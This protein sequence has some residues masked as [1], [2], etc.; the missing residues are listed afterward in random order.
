MH[1]VSRWYRAPEAIFGE[2]DYD[3]QIDNWSIGCILGE[4]IKFSNIYDT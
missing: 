3:A 1:V 4:M 2:Q